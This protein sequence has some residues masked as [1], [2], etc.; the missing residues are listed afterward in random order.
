MSNAF[1][2]EKKQKI[3]FCVLASI[4]LSFFEKS[5]FLFAFLFTFIWD[6][7]LT[8]SS[9][10]DLSIQPFLHILYFYIT[11]SPWKQNTANL[12]SIHT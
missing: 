6:F 2:F 11:K 12:N 8:H 7:L 4:S 5:F 9:H 1:S 10:K 3:C